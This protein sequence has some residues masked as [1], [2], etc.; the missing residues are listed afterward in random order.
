MLLTPVAV[1]RYR[2][3]TANAFLRSHQATAQNTAGRDLDALIDMARDR[4]DGRI[5][6]GAVEKKR[7]LPRLY[8]LPL[9]IIPDQL[10]ADSLGFNLRTDSLSAD[11]EPF[12][13]GTKLSQYDLFNVKYLLLPTGQKP[14]LEAGDVAHAARQVRAVPGRRR[15]ATSKWSTRPIRSRRIRATWRRS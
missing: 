8:I 6:A 1:N 14:P 3:G 11:I 5:Y 10:Q 9:Y 12:F 4:N 2:F 15:A 13:N 7:G